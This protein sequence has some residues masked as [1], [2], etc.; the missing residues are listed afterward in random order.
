MCRRIIGILRLSR[1]P[2]GESAKRSLMLRD[3]DAFFFFPP[4]SR[5]AEGFADNR[6]EMMEH[7]SFAWWKPLRR[8][9]NNISIA[10]CALEVVNVIS[11]GCWRYSLSEGRI[12]KY[13]CRWSQSWRKA[14]PFVYSTVE[15]NDS[16]NSKRECG[17]L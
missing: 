2:T 3:F 16:S 9:T 14:F 12:S 4:P 15:P 17:V 11:L 13:Q 6:P 8:G 10:T 7:V 1:G 5:E